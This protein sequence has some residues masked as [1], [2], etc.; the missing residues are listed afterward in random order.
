[1][2]PSLSRILAELGA[3]IRP[4]RLRR[5]LSAVQGAERAGI[6]RQTLYAI[7]RGEPGTALGNYAQVLLVLGLEKD[8][9][10]VGDDDTLGRK[11]QDARLTTPRRAPRRS[12]PDR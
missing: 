2:I 10:R 7:E 3:H 9:L 1:M 12:N 11:L 4:A 5:R 8:L 6:T